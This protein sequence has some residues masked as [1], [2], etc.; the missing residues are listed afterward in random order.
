M[1]VEY[2]ALLV[3]LRLALELSIPHLQ[4]LS[5]SQLVVGQI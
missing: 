2:E 4:I 3:R 1:E 5:D